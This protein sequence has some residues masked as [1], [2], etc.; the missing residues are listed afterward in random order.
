MSPL[1]EK[2][3]ELA[4]IAAAGPLAQPPLSK[5]DRLIARAKQVPPATTIVVHPCDET[6]LRGPVEAAESRHHHPGA[7]GSGGKDLRSG[8]LG[9]S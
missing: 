8:S 4:A 5:Y 3:T 1:A 2:V 9:S 6:S 7:R